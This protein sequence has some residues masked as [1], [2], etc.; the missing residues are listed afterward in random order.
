MKHSRR[1]FIKKSA[2]ATG[3]LSLFG[4]CGP[5]VN[6]LYQH[7]TLMQLIPLEKKSVAAY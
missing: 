3:I 2:M 4:A 6:Q 1:D 7:L 5:A